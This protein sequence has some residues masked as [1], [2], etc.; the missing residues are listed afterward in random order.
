MTS[1]LAI[2]SSLPAWT[3]EALKPNVLW[4]RGE[5]ARDH[6]RPGRLALDSPDRRVPTPYNNQVAACARYARSGEHGAGA[7]RRQLLDVS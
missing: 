3:V 5:Q 7:P 6:E 2:E 4:E 1:G